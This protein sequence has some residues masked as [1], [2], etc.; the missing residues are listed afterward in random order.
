MANTTAV[1]ELHY[2]PC[3]A[4]F[5]TLYAHEKVLIEAQ[6]NFQKQSYRNRCYIL[7]AN[8]V[9]RL[10][11]PVL[12]GQGTPVLE[13]KI[14][15]KQ[16]WQHQHWRAIESAYANAP[17]FDYY[18]PYFKDLIY[19]N[20]E[21]LFE[22]NQ[23]ILKTCLKLMGKSVE[24]G[25]TTQ[26]LKEYEGEIDDFRGKIHPKR[27]FSMIFTHYYQVFGDKFMKNLSVLDLFFCEGPNSITFVK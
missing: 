25:K 22:F 4:Y 26:F 17:Y 9:E 1:I 2:F 8:G 21:F 20:E 6:E 7:A 19:S 14:D 13:L 23:K 3:I 12:G 15:Y 16:K 5:K 24:I 10:S 18:A 11:V 27:D